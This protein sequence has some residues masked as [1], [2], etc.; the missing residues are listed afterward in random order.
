M[1]LIAETGGGEAGLIATVPASV[2]V[3]ALLSRAGSAIA[4]DGAVGRNIATFSDVAAQRDALWTMLRGFATGNAADLDA[5]IAA[6]RSGF[7]HQAPDG[8]FL[9]TLAD[10]STSLSAGT[11]FLQSF[12]RVY[13]GFQN[14][15]YW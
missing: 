9:N 7:Q 12:A 13:L 4:P 14:S 3:S 5:S 8:S 10:A 2:N 15:G 11:F 6:M 1:T